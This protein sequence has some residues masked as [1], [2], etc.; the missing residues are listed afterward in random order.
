MGIIRKFLGPKSKYNKS[1]PYTYLAK[2]PRFDGDDE[3]FAYYYSDTICGLI[4]FLEGNNIEHEHTEIYGVYRDDEVLLDLK[5]CTDSEGKWLNRPEI[6]RSL[7]Q[8]F[9]KTLEEKYR[10]HIEIGECSF[11]DRDRKG[12]GPY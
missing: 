4:E 1:L 7:E 3:I 11:E 5:L 8:H 2:T 12:I 9:K 6:C 10:G